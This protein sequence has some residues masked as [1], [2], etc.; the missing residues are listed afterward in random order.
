MKHC[1]SCFHF[2]MDPEPKHKRINGNFIW[3]YFHRCEFDH[4]QEN[5]DKP[6]CD[7]YVNRTQ[8]QAELDRQ[9]YG[10]DKPVAPTNTAT[11]EAFL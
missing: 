10:F 7:R 3:A 11:Q 1:R 9:R 6:A 5:A 4:K 2:E 8:H